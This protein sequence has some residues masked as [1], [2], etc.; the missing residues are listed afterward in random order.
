MLEVKQ[1]DDALFRLVRQIKF[2]TDYKFLDD[3]TFI[4]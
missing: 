4:V 3:T 1:K 2:Y